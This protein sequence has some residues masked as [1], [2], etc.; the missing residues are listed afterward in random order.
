MNLMVIYFGK[1]DRTRKLLLFII[2][3]IDQNMS[4]VSKYYFSFSKLQICHNIFLSIKKRWIYFL[5]EKLI[6]T[7]LKRTNDIDR[8]KVTFI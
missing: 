1:D 8:D 4:F 5:K 6:F 2:L 7:Q 3:K